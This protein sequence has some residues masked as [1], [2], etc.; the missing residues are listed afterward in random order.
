MNPIHCMHPDCNFDTDTYDKLKEH[1]RT[2]GHNESP[3][4]QKK[5]NVNESNK[6]QKKFSYN[7]VK[8]ALKYIQEN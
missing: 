2:T 8:L 5:Y 4:L 6:P 1:Y 3:L 7:R